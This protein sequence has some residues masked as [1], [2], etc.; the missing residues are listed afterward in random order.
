MHD[1]TFTR[2]RMSYDLPDEAHDLIG[3]EVQVYFNMASRQNGTIVHARETTS[4]TTG[5]SWWLKVHFP[6]ENAVWRFRMSPSRPKRWADHGAVSGDLS[7]K[8]DGVAVSVESW[9]LAD[10]D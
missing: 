3:R 6:D 7:F 8:Q 9:S 4:M 1:T 10:D 5:T 2:M